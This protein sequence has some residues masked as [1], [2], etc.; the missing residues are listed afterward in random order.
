MSQTINID[1]TPGLFMPTLYYSQGD[2]GRSYSINLTSRDGTP[3]PSSVTAVFEATK[4]S[5]FGF[6]ESVTLTG[7][8]VTFDT[9]ETMTNESGRVPAQIRL[10]KSG[11]DIGTARFWWEGEAKP[12]P[13]GSTDGDADSKIPE[14]T[15]LVERIEDAAD[16]IHNLSVDADTLGYN[17]LATASYDGGLNKIT[18]GIPRGGAMAVS[19]TSSDGDIVITFS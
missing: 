14:M 15:L 17:D 13:D 19:D 2:I 6:S 7:S 4:P 1:L 10:T 8:V 18:F 12:H 9:T 5:G 3:I 16:S 11:V